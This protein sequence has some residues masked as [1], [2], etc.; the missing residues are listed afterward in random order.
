MQGAAPFES[1]QVADIGD[2]PVN[3][4]N[5]KAAVKQ[6]HGAYADIVKDGCKPLTLGGEHT[7]SYPILQALRVC[8]SM[9]LYGSIYLYIMFV[10]VCLYLSL[11]ISGCLCQ[12]LYVSVCL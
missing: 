6:L 7:I 1:L 10:S 12:S 2:I 4:Y 9:S 5:L 8:T 3:T 11:S